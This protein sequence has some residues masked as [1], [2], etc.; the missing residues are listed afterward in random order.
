MK[1]MLTG[2]AHCHYIAAFIADSEE[3]QVH[4]TAVVASGVDKNGSAY[5]EA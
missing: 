2:I 1:Q 3:F 5:W 4:T